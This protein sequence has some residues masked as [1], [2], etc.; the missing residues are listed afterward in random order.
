VATHLPHL[1]SRQI[2]LTSLTEVEI[3]VVD[4]RDTEE[5]TLGLVE[6]PLIGHQIGE[7]ILSTTTNQAT[8]HLLQDL[9]PIITA[10][11]KEEVISPRQTGEPRVIPEAVEVTAARWETAAA[12]DL[13]ITYLPHQLHKTT[14][15]RVLILQALPLPV[16]VS[17]LP[18]TT[19][20]GKEIVSI[21]IKEMKRMTAAVATSRGSFLTVI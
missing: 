5:A 13:V 20:I 2:G 16:E 1:S 15:G 18:A 17:D 14:I 19:G 4:I 8:P 21:T 10:E 11:I 7:E 3:V 12:V 9:L 6:E